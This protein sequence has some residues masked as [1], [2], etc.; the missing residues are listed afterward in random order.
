MTKISTASE[1]N[2]ELKMTVKEWLVVLALKKIEK[3]SKLT[4]AQVDT[5]LQRTKKWLKF[6]YYTA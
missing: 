1:S 2:R 3:V 4:E 6:I 5:P